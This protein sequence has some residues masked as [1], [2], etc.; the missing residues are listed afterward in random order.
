MTYVYKDNGTILDNWLYASESQA[1]AQE[2]L[3]TKLVPQN[4]GG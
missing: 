2:K 1:V 3:V 4:I